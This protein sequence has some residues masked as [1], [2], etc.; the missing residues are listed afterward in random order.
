MAW[1]GARRSELNGE[2]WRE[3]LV[4]DAHTFDSVEAIAAVGVLVAVVGM[5]DDV[6]LLGP[7][8]AGCRGS[9][10]WSRRPKARY[11]TTSVGWR[12][13]AEGGSMGRQA[14]NLSKL[15]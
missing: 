1:N 7:A 6:P 10:R 15:Q 3:A 13:T 2:A 12:C 5:K 11:G 14:T 4:G 9:I 8:Q